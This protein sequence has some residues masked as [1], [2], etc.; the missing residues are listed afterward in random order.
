[1][2]PAWQGIANEGGNHRTN[3]Q[4]PFTTN[5]EQTTF[6]SQGH[7]QTSKDVWRGPHGSFAESL[8][9]AKCPLRKAQISGEGITTDHSDD[10]PT[11]NNSRD[12]GQQRYKQGIEEFF[13]SLH[14]CMPHLTMH[15]GYNPPRGWPI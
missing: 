12:N 9:G 14:G 10:N 15:R 7:S 4:L 5:I 6:E 8:G 11:D 3:S 13:Y 2:Q 1:M